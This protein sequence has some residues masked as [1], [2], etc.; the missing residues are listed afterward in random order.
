MKKVVL[1]LLLAVMVVLPVSVNAMTES[2][3][4]EKLAASYTVNGRTDSL[5]DSVLV[6]IDRYLSTYELSSDDCDYISDKIDEGLEIGRAGTAT[7]W[8]ELTSS[9]KEK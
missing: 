6:I 1:V 8:H 4:R 2:E 7:E 9:E 5:D 3:L